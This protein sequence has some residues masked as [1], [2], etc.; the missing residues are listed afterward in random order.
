M[1]PTVSLHNVSKIY[2]KG[3]SA[4]CALSGVTLDIMP[5]EVV[6]IVGP[7]GSGKTTLLTLAGLVE[8]PT[9]G[10]IHLG[11]ATVIT[12]AT[13][14]G[15]LRAL[16]RQHIGFIFQKANLAD[17]LTATEN[18]ALAGIVQGIQAAT[19]RRRAQD[20]LAL[21]DLAERLNHYPSQLSGGE[22]QRVSL[23]RSLMGS[24]SLLLADEPTAALDAGRRDQIMAVLQTMAKQQGVA[25]CIV[26]HDPRTLQYC[27][28]AV[29]IADGRLVSDPPIGLGASAG[30][31]SA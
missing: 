25:M 4:V 14:D 3:R 23:A 5:R 22:Q 20:L 26:T 19:A 2:G 24:P 11:A 6:G 21:L 9:S 30:A 17:F 16:R 10:R 29:A 27:D 1:R 28:R 12:A 15:R 7:S 13:R 18:V 8:P 31:Q